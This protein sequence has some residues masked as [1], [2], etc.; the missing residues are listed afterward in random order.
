MNKTMAVQGTRAHT[1]TAP[2]VM[3][4]AWLLS[5]ANLMNLVIPWSITIQRNDDFTVKV[6]HT[7]MS[8]DTPAH[9]NLY[10]F[11]HL[12]HFIQLW[13]LLHVMCLLIPMPL[14]GHSIQV[15]G[16]FALQIVGV[17]NS[18]CSHC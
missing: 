2:Q 4:I 16:L 8:I 10:V 7:V 13:P 12:Q 9:W 5:V 18:R 14:S 11:H 3:T 1:T 17:V 15:K 6:N